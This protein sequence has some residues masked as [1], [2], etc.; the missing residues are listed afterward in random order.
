[1]ASVSTLEDASDKAFDV[2]S[3]AAIYKTKTIYI[4]LAHEK[5][6]AGQKGARITAGY[7]FSKDNKIG[8]G[9]ESGKYAS[10][11]DHKAYI[12]NGVMKLSE[13]YKLKA[14]YGKRTAAKDETAYA[15]A[16]VRDLGDKSELYAIFH[17][18]K[19]ENAST[20]VQTLS[21]GMTYV[22]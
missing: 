10:G 22:F 16:L 8:V 1:M 7:T 14:S 4:G 12:V 2:E 3:I 19:D 18:D 17:S 20:D 21:L 15:I 9:Y 5:V 13:L 6:D 11:A